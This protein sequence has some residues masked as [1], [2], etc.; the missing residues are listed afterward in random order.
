MKKIGSIIII[1]ILLLSGFGVAAAN[2]E[3]KAAANTAANLDDVPVWNVGNSWTYSVSSITVN[4]NHQGQQILMNGKIDDF[5]WTVT[6]TTGDYYTVALTG[7]LTATYDLLLNTQTSTLHLVGSFTPTLTRLTGTIQLTKSDLQVHAM[8]LQLVGITKTKINTLSF[9]LPIPFKL[10][11]Q[12]SLTTDFPLFDFPLYMLKFWDMPDMTLT[13]SS[14]FGGI[15]GLIQIPFTVSVHYSWSPLAFYTLGTEDVTVPAGT[16]NAYKIN[17]LI[18]D[19]F[20][21]YYASE[22]GNLVKIDAT[23]PNGAIHGEL[24]A[25]TYP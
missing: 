7:K 25:T 11:S 19:Y 18:S 15:F 21:Y 3:T 24:K 17:S 9:Y 5:T 8:Y 13:M 16:Y 4:Y 23:L 2:T 10:V 22:V 14:T 1:G 12:G 6:D 20:A